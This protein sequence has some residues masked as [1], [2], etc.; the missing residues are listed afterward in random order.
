M[1]VKVLL[2]G[3]QFDGFFKLRCSPDAQ[4]EFAEIA[5]EMQRQ[6]NNNAPTQL[7]YGE[8]H[9]PFETEGYTLENKL[10]VTTATTARFSYNNQDKEYDLAKNVELHDKLLSSMHMSPFEHSAKVVP[11]DLDVLLPVPVPELPNYAL[12]KIALDAK[13]HDY[14]FW[15]TEYNMYR[16]TRQ[17]GGFYTYRAHIEDA[18]PVEHMQEIFEAL[19]K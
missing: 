16:W 14:L 15:D 12:G 8:W 17:Y 19:N 10:K 11:V 2:S 18:L 4:P 5:Y 1:R 6:Y 7:N 9:I 3:T 13:L